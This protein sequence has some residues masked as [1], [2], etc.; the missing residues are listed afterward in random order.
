MTLPPILD[1]PTDERAVFLPED[2]LERA[3]VLGGKERGGI[4]SCC[5]LDFDGELVPVAREQF[6]AKPCDAWACFHTTL[7]RVE[8][9]G[10]EMG[11]IGGTVG[12]PF[13]VL[14]AEE[15]I[16]SGCRFIIG[17]GSAGAVAEGVPLPCLVV[18]DRAL[19]DEGTSY[20]YLPPTTWVE[21][22]GRLPGVLARWA[23]DTGLPV[24]RGATWTTDAPYRETRSQVG[25]YREAGV[26]SVEMESAALLALA[27][28]R[29]AEIASL[30]HVTNHMAS[31]EGDFHKGPEDIHARVITCC[32]DAFRDARHP[33]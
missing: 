22:Q 15:L 11:L 1:H 2:L 30:L 17:Y 13:A 33:T 23:Q 20:H 4:P 8:V 21:T 5:V 6:G 31:G 32:L 10:A 28:A 3:A 19:R 27:Q 9:A 14:V 12:A 29:D 24:H 26:L 7:F 25:R 18:P 16:A